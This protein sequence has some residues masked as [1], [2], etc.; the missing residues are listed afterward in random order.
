MTGNGSSS[1]GVMFVWTMC[2]P[3]DVVAVEI[4]AVRWCRAGMSFEVG[5]SGVVVVALRSVGWRA[6]SLCI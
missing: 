3:G 4:V 1:S 5:S 2:R 6:V